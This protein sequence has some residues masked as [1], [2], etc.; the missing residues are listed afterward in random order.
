MKGEKLSLATGLS[1]IPK[2]LKIGFHIYKVQKVPYWEGGDDGDAGMIDYEKG[3]IY[4]NSKMPQ[5][6]QERTL[7]HEIGH[8]INTV[9]DHT[10]LES[11]S[12]Q[13]YQV[14]HDN[15]LLR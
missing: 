1:Q 10:L 9:I 8:S 14:L 7:F 5:T 11:L 2:K 6:E 13:L 4:I 12:E 15:K 3:V